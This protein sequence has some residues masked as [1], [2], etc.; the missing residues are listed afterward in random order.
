[1]EYLRV[2]HGKALVILGYVQTVK[3]RKLTLSKLFKLLE[4]TL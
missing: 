4:R 3:C 1:M 2:R